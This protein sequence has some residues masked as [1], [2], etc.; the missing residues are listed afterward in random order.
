MTVLMRSYVS[1]ADPRKIIAE[2]R[3]QLA[4]RTAE[5]DEAIAQ[6]TA[7]ADVLRVINSSPG[8]LAPVFDAILDQATRLCDAAFGV[9]WTYDRSAKRYRPGWVHQVP[10]ALAEFLGGNYR[11][12]PSGVLNV[13]GDASFLHVL[14]EAESAG[15]RTG[16]SQLRRAMVDLGGAHTTLAVPLRRHDTVLAIYRQEVRAFS[17]RQ[18]ALLQNFAQQAVMA[19]ENARLLTETRE[20]LEQQTGNAEVLQVI[21][22]SPGDVAPV[23]DAMLE[24]GVGLCEADLGVLHTFDGEAFPLV[25]I[26]G[27][28]R[29]IVEQLKQLSP[30]RIFGLLN[31]I[32]RGERVVHVA[33]VRKTATYRD[34][35]NS[36]NRFQLANLRTWLGVALR[37]EDALLG[38]IIVVRREVRPFSDKQIALLQNFAAQ[39]V[40]AIEN[41]RLLGEL[42]QRTGDLQESLEY[43]T[44]TSDVLQVINSSPGDLIPVFDAILEKAHRLCGATH[45]S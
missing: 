45:G 4:E 1:S 26:C 2:L 22:S 41:A 37:K 13:L 12:P 6:Q 42:Q 21:N 7:T 36:R 32:V 11:A 18:I 28:D 19:M 20:A 33:D 25:A 27:H 38:V 9:V 14:D 8:E 17:E 23:F 10:G 39:A 16:A 44:A 34:Y 31:P 30:I 35:Q 3:Q 43:Q 40:I 29:K 5:R 24:K 15:Y